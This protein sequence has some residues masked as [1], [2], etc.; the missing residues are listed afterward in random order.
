MVWSITW[1]FNVFSAPKSS[2]GTL[3]S[4]SLNPRC[5]KTTQ[6]R[7]P[8][9]D[10]ICL[11]IVLVSHSV[12]SDSWQP[13]RRGCLPAS[14]V[15]GVLQ[16]RILEWVAFPSPGDLPDPGIKSR[17]PELQAD[18][19][20]S[21]PQGKPY[22]LTPNTRWIFIKRVKGYFLANLNISTFR[23]TD[24]IFKWLLIIFNL[25]ILILKVMYLYIKWNNA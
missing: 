10:N 9:D 17:S 11:E 15:H 18:S 16:V 23:A 21:E 20:P 13:H 19:L 2:W 4:P 14:S 3:H 1:S 7:N 8:Y 12:M 5:Y 25:Y 24:E 6:N 22:K